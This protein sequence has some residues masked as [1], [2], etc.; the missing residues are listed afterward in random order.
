M[1]WFSRPKPWSSTGIS[2]TLRR[3]LAG[4]LASQ[5][6]FV[7]V[8]TLSVICLLVS[9]ANGSGDQH[10]T[11][12]AARHGIF[13]ALLLA[14]PATVLVWNPYW[15]LAGAGFEADLIDLMAPYLQPAGQKL[16]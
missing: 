9:Q 16:P 10:G 8:G 12:L 1:R 5:I 11:S 6:H 4:D 13:V 7:L 2:R 15:L 14:L 3:W